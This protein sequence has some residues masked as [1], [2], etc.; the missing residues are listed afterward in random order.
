MSATRRLGLMAFLAASTIIAGVADAG[1]YRRGGIV[2]TPYGSANMNSPEWK[3]SGGD[4]RV[5]QRLMQQKQMMLQQRAMMKKREAFLKQQKKGDRAQPSS[6]A[7]GPAAAR[8]SRKKQSTRKA[9]PA[10][11]PD[12]KAQ[13]SAKTAGP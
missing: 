3:R 7:D 10:S 12:T 4:F 1:G 9:D 11:A 5:Y 6:T 8:K 2:R 13:K